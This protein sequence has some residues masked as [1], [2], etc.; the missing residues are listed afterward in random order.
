MR[1]LSVAELE[2]ALGHSILLPPD[3]V[4][5][6]GPYFAHGS[7]GVF[8]FLIFFL[9]VTVHVWLFLMRTCLCPLC[10]RGLRRVTYV[11]PVVVFQCVGVTFFSFLW[12]AFVFFVV[13]FFVF[14]VCTFL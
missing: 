8:A 5:P 11:H 7:E 10:F 9:S 3:D 13:A 12:F 4:V 6:L 1:T 14:V 2:Q